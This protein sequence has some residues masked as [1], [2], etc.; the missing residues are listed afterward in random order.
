M[1]RTALLFAIAFAIVVSV[2]AQ[3]PDPGD[4]VCAY[5]NVDLKSQQP[6]KRGC[7]YYEEPSSESSSSSSSSSSFSTSKQSGPSPTMPF[8]NGRCPECGKPCK[9]LAY[10]AADN[11]HSGC[12]LGEAIKDYWHYSH[13][14]G[15]LFSTKTGKI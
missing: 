12:R 8:E 5:C 14:W 13:I 6:H 15:T 9:P 10:I 4:P 3:I 11:I 2:Q 1:K 7:P